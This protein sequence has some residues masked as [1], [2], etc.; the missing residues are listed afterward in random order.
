MTLELIKKKLKERYN[1]TG[2]A[3]QGKDVMDALSRYKQDD[4]DKIWLKFDSEYL[5]MGAPK[6][7]NFHSIAI[8]LGLI[9]QADRGQTNAAWICANN[10]CNTRYSP[11]TVYICPRCGETK[12]AGLGD[13]AHPKAAIVN[14]DEQWYKGRLAE[15]AEDT[16]NK[17]GVFEYKA[18]RTKFQQD[19]ENPPLC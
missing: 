8:G 17:S 18:L 14:E 1:Y 4:L 6:P 13:Q 12:T 9:G 11:L 15:M 10:D 19:I 7:A 3:A 16:I 5:G 2:K